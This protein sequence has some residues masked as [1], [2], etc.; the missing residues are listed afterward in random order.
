MHE[1]S[2]TP[3]LIAV[4]RSDGTI[5]DNPGAD[6]RVADGDALFLIGTE[7][8]VRQMEDLGRG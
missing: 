6:L 5:V 8:Q 1:Q 2:F 7:A 4:A 3:L